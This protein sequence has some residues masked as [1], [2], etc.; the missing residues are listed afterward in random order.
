MT[1]IKI[2]FN[3][4]EYNNNLRSYLSATMN[5]DGATINFGGTT[6]N[7][8]SAKLES[9][10]NDF[11]AHIRAL[12]GSSLEPITWDG[13]IGDRVNV[14]LDNDGIVVLVKVS[15]R[16]LTVSDCIGSEVCVNIAGSNNLTSINS[17]GV[18]EMPG[19]IGII[20]NSDD[21]L[22][23]VWS[24]EDTEQVGGLPETGTYFMLSNANSMYVQSLTFAGGSSSGDIKLTI[25][26]NKYLIDSV[27][28][29][30]AITA[31]QE[32]LGE[33]SE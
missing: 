20:A 23:V 7:I 2:P 1:K 4:T 9:A 32:T 17:D 22:P 16:V 11:V 31:L 15:D 6:Y 24:I 14:N 21:D 26:E 33:L 18:I 28:L 19:F 5:G 10:T 12:S 25:S 29:S 30:D 13:V 27:K 8:D 3:G